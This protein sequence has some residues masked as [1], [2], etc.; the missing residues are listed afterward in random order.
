LVRRRRPWQTVVAGFSLEQLMAFRQPAVLLAAIMV[1][2]IAVAFAAALTFDGRSL[3]MDTEIVP[4]CASAGLGVLQNVSGTTVVSVTVSGLP[5]A[6]G[7][8]TLQVTVNNLV[9]SSSGSA[10]V[11]GGGGSVTVTL[12]TAV[13][14]TA[15]EQVDL[16]LTGP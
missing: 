11:P 5:S 1:A 6:C 15:A 4:R 16:L 7:S 9:T 14:I 10:T 13:A 8:A 3:G 12:G 2:G